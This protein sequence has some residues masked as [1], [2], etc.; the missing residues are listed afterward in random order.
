[1]TK[2]Y[3]LLASTTL[4]VLSITAQEGLMHMGTAYPKVV[5]GLEGDLQLVTNGTTDATGS[6]VLVVMEGAGYKAVRLGADMKPGEELSLRQ[7][8][9]DGVKWDAVTSLATDASGVRS[10]P[11]SCQSHLL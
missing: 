2:R 1:M 6:P 10:N 8:T 3:A 7:Q 9:F 4:F 11:S 5:K